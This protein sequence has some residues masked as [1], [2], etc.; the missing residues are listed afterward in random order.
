MNCNCSKDLGCFMSC[1]N[2]DFGFQ[3]PW[4]NGTQVTFEIWANGGFLTQTF[5]FDL[6]DQIQIPYVFN[7]NGETMIKIQV[8]AAYSLTYFTHVTIDGACMFMAKGIPG[9][10][11]PLTSCL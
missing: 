1:E 11:Q 6:G 10:C 4:P 2:I 9:I 3:S 8:P 5:T 7:E